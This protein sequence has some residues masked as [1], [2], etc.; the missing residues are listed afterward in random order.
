VGSTAGSGVS[1]AEAFRGK[2]RRR[3]GRQC[4]RHQSPT[5]SLKKAPIFPGVTGSFLFDS[6]LRRASQARIY[7]HSSCG[8]AIRHPARVRE[9]MTAPYLLGSLQFT[10]LSGGLLHRE[11]RSLT[12]VVF[13]PG[14][15]T[16]G[17]PVTPR[18]R[19]GVLILLMGQTGVLQ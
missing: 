13:S 9:S 5:G 2:T 17:A 18:V 14:R 11:H 16:A 1:D 3:S 15:I 12:L 19:I 7:F 10:L 8:A 4:I 6:R